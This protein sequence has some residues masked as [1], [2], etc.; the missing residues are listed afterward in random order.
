MSDIPDLQYG[1]LLDSVPAIDFSREEEVWAR[2]DSLTKPPRSLGR[3][4]SLAV[5]V[6]L[7]EETLE[8][9]ARRKTVI[10][11]AADHGVVAEQVSPYPQDVTAQMVANFEGGGA[12]INQIADAVGADLVVADFGVA[13]Q[14]PSPSGVLDHRIANGTSNMAT[15]PAM[16]RNECVA[17]IVAGAEISREAIERGTE[18]IAT[19]EMGIGNTTAAAALVSAYTDA[20]VPLVVGPGTGLDAEGVIRKQHVVQRALDINGVSSLD[21][22]GVLAAVGGLEIAG[23]VGVFVECASARVPVVIDGFIS[24]AAAL[25]A[26]RICPHSSAYSI[27]S[28]RSSEPGHSILLEALEK[29]PVFDLEMRLGEGTG[30]ALALPTIDAACRMMSNMATFADAGV[31]VAES[32]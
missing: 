5:Q 27:A 10:I 32:T 26:A 8:P 2:L 3:L 16:T 22:L 28:H 18:I 25:A 6:A 23:L 31:S 9:V 14:L 24:G 21:P 19:G 12:A 4:E 30:A 7:I 17:A 11:A 15:G 20:P 1:R 13:G 29:T